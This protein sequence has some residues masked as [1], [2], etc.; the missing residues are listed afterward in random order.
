MLSWMRNGASPVTYCAQSSAA[1]LRS[2]TMAVSAAPLSPAVSSREMV[3]AMS[4]RAGA[5]PVLVITVVVPT[6]VA[7]KLAPV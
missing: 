6:V 1:A 4:S 3:N 5:P 7:M 2:L